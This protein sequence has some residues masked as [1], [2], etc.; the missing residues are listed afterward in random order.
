M[1][2]GRWRV[3][4]PRA[5]RVEVATTDGSITTMHRAPD[6]W[7][8]AEVP[9]VLP[10]RLVLDGVA[11]PDPWA[12]AQPDGFDGP[13]VWVDHAAFVWTDA[14]WRGAPLRDAVLYELH[15]GTF[16]EAGTFD[17]AI[18][19]LDHLV[20]LGVTAVEL[21][22]VATFPGSRGWGYDGVQL[23]A[24][25]HAYGG[26]YGGPDG[27][28]RFV[29]AC[30]A[31]HLAV[32]LDVVYNHLG[33]LGNHLA[34]FGPWFT[35]E[36]RTPWG[37][38]VNLDGRGS[39]AV[40]E[41]I[42]DNA[43]CWIE[44]YHLDGLRL[45]AVHALHDGSAMHIV[46]E[47][48][49]ELHRA[50][51]HAQRTVW[52]IAESDLNDPRVVR[53]PDRGGHGA[54]AAWSDDFHHALHTVIT[55]ERERYYADYG[56]LRQLARSLERVFVY[57]G[58][59]APH[60]GRRHGRPVGD[61]PRTRFVGYSQTHDQ[62]G[63][64]ARGERLCHLTDVD[65][66]AVAA[67]LVLTSPFVPML[68]QGEEW[69]ASTPFLYVT[70]MPDEALGDAIRQGRSLEF[71]FTDDG[72]D[73]PDPQSATTHRSSVLRWDEVD[74]E[75]HRA[76]LAWYR[77]LIRLRRATPALRSD[78]VGDTCA[79]TGNGWIA[80]RRGD[81]LVIAAFDDA[82]VAMTELPDGTEQLR[83]VTLS[84]PAGLHAAD[85]AWAMPRHGV[86]V[87]GP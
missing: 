66:A 28:K 15:V 68:F 50:G 75:P 17:G 26:A 41:L 20:R 46:E 23:A 39:D 34:R 86:V 16:T 38:G 56:S 72:G 61:L 73:V 58:G 44:H 59:H 48:A 47:I 78:G 18:E 8:T 60:R 87:V 45:D 63:N 3:W 4:A 81:H 10:Y 42:V 25:H 77:D 19:R 7:W 79:T 30:H 64:R 27:M 83:R 74:R 67:A 53:E 14:T 33:P 31:R 24:P 29:D 9:P 49:T 62:V 65:G 54:D 21:M 11:V 37:Q 70:D 32:V 69:A 43:R 85:G 35:D 5:G 12:Q 55:G 76:M 84:W 57:D 71:G 6:G 2:P 52:V 22:P 13:S 36:H 80:V 82:V 1:S 40:R 51:Q